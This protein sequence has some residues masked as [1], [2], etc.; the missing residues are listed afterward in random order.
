MRFYLSIFLIFLLIPSIFS[1][2][3][4][5]VSI[6]GISDGRKSSE[7]VDRDEA[8]MD[9]KL[10]AVER[11]GVNIKSVTEI[12][13]FVMKK[14]WIESKAEAYLMPGYQIIDV[15]Y[16]ADRLYHVVLVGK[17]RVMGASSESDSDTMT[18]NDGRSYKTVKIG[19]QVWMAENLRETKYRNGDAIQRITNNSLWV[20]SQNGSY[21][22][23]ANDGKK[24]E[25][26]GCLYNW[27]AVN[28]SRNI[29]P[30]GW[31]VPSDSEWQTL[32]DHLGGEYVAGGKIKE[33]GTAHWKGSNAG[34][35]NESGFT[36]LPGGYRYGNVGSFD[37][38][39]SDASFWSST[40]NGVHNAWYRNLLSG[41]TDVYR[42]E[43]NKHYGFSVR[44]LRDN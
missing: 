33:T 42:E 43:I 39:G 34:A 21:C 8:I 13:N 26:Y 3:I 38:L 14:D 23:Y 15:G 25:T 22:V 32:L 5:D 44:L 7:R 2:E 30:P 1:Q 20:Y 27:L 10:Q 29:A 19:N 37:G 40:E 41:K 11:A 36:A 17:V 9:A 6:K 12:E 28:D 18:G 16:G 31:H 4:I 35:T 24:L